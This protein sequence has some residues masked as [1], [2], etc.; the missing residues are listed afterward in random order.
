MALRCLCAWQAREAKRAVR[1]LTA[2]IDEKSKVLRELKQEKDEN[3]SLLHTATGAAI[4]IQ[5]LNRGMKGRQASKLKRLQQ[6][7]ALTLQRVFRGHVDR[8]RAAVVRA[9]MQQTDAT[10][11]E[12]LL[13]EINELDALRNKAM[14]ELKQAKQRYNQRRNDKYSSA[15]AR[16]AAPGATA[17]LAKAA[18]SGPPWWEKYNKERLR[19]DDEVLARDLSPPADASSRDALTSK[20]VDNHARPLIC[21]S[22]NDF[23]EERSLLRSEFSSLYE[24]CAER[25]VAFSPV[26]PFMQLERP[27]YGRGERE[28]QWT[29]TEPKDQNPAAWK[30]DL[31]WRC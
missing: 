28:W 23:R 1:R 10:V 21:T 7:R 14:V 11:R 31:V 4:Q 6:L 29:L 12:A 18:P 25:G 20:E 16:I 2:E 8:K 9:A 22:Y 3:E 24:L 13:Q 30:D 19:D 26:D 27:E 17:S 5:R 15:I